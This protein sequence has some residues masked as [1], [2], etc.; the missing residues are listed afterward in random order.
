MLCLWWEKI[1]AFIKP[2]THPLP[3]TSHCV[4]SEQIG[5]NKLRCNSYPAWKSSWP[6]WL[7]DV[8]GSVREWGAWVKIFCCQFLD[9]KPNPYHVHVLIF[10]VS[11]QQIVHKMA[12]SS[13]TNTNTNTTQV[14]LYFLGDMSVWYHPCIL[15]WTRY[16][17]VAF[18]PLIL[19]LISV[20]ICSLC[21]TTLIYLLW[22][23][24]SGILLQVH[25]LVS[26]L[27][28]S[29]MIKNKL[30]QYFYY[31]YLLYYLLQLPPMLHAFHHYK[32]PGMDFCCSNPIYK[33]FPRTLCTPDIELLINSSIIIKLSGLRTKYP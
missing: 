14:F 22:S 7:Q 9:F 11:V 20:S 2:F 3:A 26:L 15:M 13:Y 5:E 12:S 33:C 21:S 32:Y 8:R 28:F 10:K 17:L 1:C 24:T 18:L 23:R 4:L 6:L 25:C 27:L 29:S 19:T 30:W 16:Q 31:F